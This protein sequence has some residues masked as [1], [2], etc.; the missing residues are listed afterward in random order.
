[1]YSLDGKHA[2]FWIDGNTNGAYDNLPSCTDGKWCLLKMISGDSY[3]GIIEETKQQTDNDIECISDGI[4]ENCVGHI[5]YAINIGRIDNPSWYDTMENK[6]G[7]S[8]QNATLQDFQRWFKCIDMH[9]SDCNDK[10]LTF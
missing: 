10:G 8:V 1:M 6:S 2:S 7:I 3:S 5:C 9:P 4:P